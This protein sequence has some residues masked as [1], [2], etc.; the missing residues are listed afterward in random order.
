MAYIIVYYLH[1]ISPFTFTF[2]LH[3]SVWRVSGYHDNYSLLRSHHHFWSCCPALCRGQNKYRHR[4]CHSR[5]IR[6]EVHSDCGI[7]DCRNI[8]HCSDL[9]HQENKNRYNGYQNN[10]YLHSAGVPDYT[11]AC[12]YVYYNCSFYQFLDHCLYFYLQ[13]RYCWSVQWFALCL[14]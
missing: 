13:F 9:Q 2:A 4:Q 5:C 1:N 10:C 11:C 3:Q 12:L 8:F 6:D 14:Y 7:C